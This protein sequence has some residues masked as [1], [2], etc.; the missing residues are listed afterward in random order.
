MSA[1]PRRPA[2][3]SA[4]RRPRVV[5]IGGGHGL[6]ASLRALRR[7]TDELVAVVG[8]S[9][10]GGS[11]GR[12]RREFGVPPPGDLRMA[13]AALCGDDAWGRTWSRV[14]QHRFR[15]DGELAGHAVGNLLIT[16][17]WEE[18][19][20]VVAGLEWVA[21]LLGAHGRVLPVATTGLEVVADV[22]GTDPT[23]PDET[24]EV[25]GQVAVA[26]S[27]GDVVGLRLVPADVTACPP[28]LDA[29]AAADV[30][31]LGP[32]SWFTS[33]LAPVLVPG[34]AAALASSRARVVVV[35]NVGRQDN[36]APGTLPQD[37]LRVLRDHVPSLRIDD[38][39][40][41]AHEVQEHVDG[42]RAS[43]DAIG[44]GLVV[45]PLAARDGSATHDVDL[46]ASA[47]GGVL[48]PR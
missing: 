14:V 21:A 13:L 20:D 35:L 45:A 32:G 48:G 2:P 9:D 30:V 23:R 38:V 29:I 46:L 7:V 17:L 33:V 36:E 31:V 10:D 26:T 3:P 34:I 1:A 22:R 16:A 27:P 11:S 6:S 41:D 44:A 19:G 39:L 43:C 15:G 4:D 24:V 8:V 37:D 47:L 12:L 25:R 18:T 40:A 28:A 5:A 42:L